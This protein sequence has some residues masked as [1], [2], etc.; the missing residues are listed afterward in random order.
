M[1]I[2]IEKNEMEGKS[3]YVNS[4]ADLAKVPASHRKL[5]GRAVRLALTEPARYFHDLAA[6]AKRRSLGRWLKTLAHCETCFLELHIASA[7]KFP[8]F[9]SAAYFRFS[10]EDD[11]EPAISLRDDQMP[12]KATTSLPSVLAE[13]YELIDGINH[14]GYGMEGGLLSASDITPFARTGF[15]LSESNTVDP[16]TCF[17]F[18]TT[19]NGNTLGF[20][21]PDRA[22]WYA[23]EVG[24]LQPAGSLRSMIDRYFRLLIEGEI[25]EPK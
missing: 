21:P 7:K 10:L 9:P 23:H 24:E 13:V 18:Y 16:E 14:F 19:L 25:L 15:W 20:Q 5:V 1:A 17:V 11:F 6:K 12:S 22:V 3:V 4:A 2:V 8:G